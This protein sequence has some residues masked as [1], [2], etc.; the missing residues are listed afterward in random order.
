MGGGRGGRGAVGLAVC[1]VVVVRHAEGEVW[2]LGGMC[3]W[4]NIL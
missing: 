3:V 2:P 4:L 1:S